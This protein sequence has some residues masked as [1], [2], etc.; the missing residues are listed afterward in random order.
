MKKENIKIV[1]EEELREM[2][3]K[4]IPFTTKLGVAFKYATPLTKEDI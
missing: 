2:F 1:E 3:R 4:G